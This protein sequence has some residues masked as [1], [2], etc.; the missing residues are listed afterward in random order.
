MVGKVPVIT[1][2]PRRCYIDLR[3][4]L[5][6]SSTQVQ[7]VTQTREIDCSAWAT[8]NVGDEVVFRTG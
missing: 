8:L 2:H 5:P 1:R 4:E 7:I 3:A 6:Y